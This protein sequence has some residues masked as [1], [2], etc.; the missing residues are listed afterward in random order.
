M[1]ARWGSARRVLSKFLAFREISLIAEPLMGVPFAFP[2]NMET[3]S[4]LSR[5]WTCKF[6]TLCQRM[7]SARRAIGTDPTR[8]KRQLSKVRDQYFLIQLLLDT[9]GTT[10]RYYSY[11][12]WYWVLLLK[13]L[14]VLKK[15]GDHPN[16]R[17]N[18]LG[19][20]RPFSELRESSGVFSEQLLEFR[21]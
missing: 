11:D 18:A 19:V 6:A 13:L 20:K 7:Q 8:S 9:A 10:S 4:F 21:K 16:F 3:Q 5:L 1:T 17:K 14:L 15:P 2:D 12:Y